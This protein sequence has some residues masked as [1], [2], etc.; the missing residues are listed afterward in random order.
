[1]TSLFGKLGFN[2]DTNEFGDGQYL[3]PQANAFLNAAPMRVDSWMQSDIAN[4]NIQM[5]NY[6]KNPLANDCISLLSNT[7]GIFTIANTIQFS[8]AQANA[9]YLAESANT[10][11]IEL[12]QF[13]SHTDNISGVVTMTSNTDTIPSLDTATAIGNQLLRILSTT[14][15]IKNTTPMLGSMTS[16]FI[17]EEVNSNVIIIASD[18]ITLNNAISPVNGNC[19]LSVTQVETINTHINIL[20]NY[21]N[22]RRTSDWNFYTNAY[23]IV[24]DTMKLTSFNTIGNTQN[25]LINNLIGTD[26]LKADLAAS[27]NANTA[28]TTT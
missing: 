11:L 7:N 17:G 6:Y 22:Y 26:K 10:L 24:S 21:I 5:T 4:G 28:N 13:K 23:V 14:D 12:E 25:Y 1:M 20:S 15:N 8:F 19:T 3:S 18:F 2:F 16:L 27:A 9:I